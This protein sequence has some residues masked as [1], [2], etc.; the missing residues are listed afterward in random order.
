MRIKAKKG[1]AR[2][3]GDKKKGIHGRRGMETER[4]RKNK[5]TRAIKR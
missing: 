2:R 5:R 4:N 1:K 3:M